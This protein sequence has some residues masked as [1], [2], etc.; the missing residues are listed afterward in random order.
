MT[1]TP[2]ISPKNLGFLT[3]AL[4][5][6]STVGLSA[7]LHFPEVLLDDR[8]FAT[9]LIAAAPAAAILSLLA[10]LAFG[11]SHT[12]LAADKLGRAAGSCWAL[13]GAL[14]LLWATSLGP[15]LSGPVFVLSTLIA[16]LLSGIWTV[17][18]SGGALATIGLLLTIP[19]SAVWVF[20]MI[21]PQ[22]DGYYLTSAILSILSLLG[23]PLWIWWLVRQSLGRTKLR[24]LVPVLVIAYAFTMTTSTP[25]PKTDDVPTVPSA[26]GAARYI[27]LMALSSEIALLP[28]DTAQLATQRAEATRVEVPSDATLKNVN[29]DG[30][31][32][33]YICGT[34]ASGSR[35]ILQIPGGGFTVPPS[36]TARIFAAHVSQQTGACVLMPHYRLAPEHPFPAAVQDCVTAYRWI[37]RQGVP[38][39]R[40]VIMG[41]SAGGNLTLTTALSLRDK[42]EDL[43]AALVDISGVTDFTLSQKT[44]HT[45]AGGEGL[46]SAGNQEFTQRSYALAGT[47][48][49]R[50]PLLSPLYANVKGLPPTLL[51][52]GSQEVLLTDTT[53]MA[54]RLRDGGVPVKLEVW[55][56]MPHSWQSAA[57]ETMETRLSVRHVSTFIS[58]HL[59]AVR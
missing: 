18:Q 28:T 46:L 15:A 59:G 38:A 26:G 11:V 34:G 43:P 10:L 49:L 23:Y 41:D 48:N 30:V 29:A 36:N 3:A 40:T 52:V 42:G 56:G 51:M 35:L 44:F 13:S 8:T 25:T 5:L 58:Q 37:R 24:F 2:K 20:D 16:P 50:D 17:R 33:E 39:K 54:D 1:K 22:E 53:R 4:G 27:A 55:P 19:R 6:A 14:G 47:E 45:K 7:S 31:P 32:A 9:S 21:V 57:K 12:A